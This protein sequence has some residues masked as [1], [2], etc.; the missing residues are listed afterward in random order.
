M[1]KAFFLI[2]IVFV[3]IS[4][5]FYYKTSQK[6][7]E[8][9]KNI[10]KFLERNLSLDSFTAESLL[11][12]TKGQLTGKTIFKFTPNCW[13]MTIKDPPL[14]EKE[15]VSSWLKINDLLYIKNYQDES[16]WQANIKEAK[17]K[18]Q[19][20]SAIDFR[21]YFR[22]PVDKKLSFHYLKKELC[23]QKYCFQYEVIDKRIQFPERKT[24]NHYIWFDED[25]FLLRKEE[26]VT[27]GKISLTSFSH[28]DQTTILSPK[29][30]QPPQ[31]IKKAPSDISIFMLPGTV[32]LSAY[33]ED[34]QPLPP[35]MPI[36]IP[37]D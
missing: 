16:W 13:Q 33:Q 3:I 5:S 21:S 15:E 1:K 9:D 30:M 7:K 23:G 34:K 27:A 11:Y 31:E 8:L 26:Y 12:N 14:K 6:A 19:F 2:P 25:D 32:R 28:Q 37:K 29:E 35:I 4:S 17:E 36:F 22:Q 20:T 24:I 18:P 10:Q